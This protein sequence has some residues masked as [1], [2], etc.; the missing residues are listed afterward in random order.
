MIGPPRG[1]GFGS[2]RDSP[3]YDAASTGWRRW[4]K[5]DWT[6]IRF[7]V[8]CSCFGAGG[9]IGSKS[10]GGMAMATDSACLRN[11]WNR[12]GSSGRKRPTAWFAHAGPVVDAAGRHRLAASGADRAVAG[13]VTIY[14]EK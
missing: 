4:C 13:G 12:G 11:A 6:P 2:R 7:P 5:R 3:I 14:T 10:C 8:R 1:R 9:V